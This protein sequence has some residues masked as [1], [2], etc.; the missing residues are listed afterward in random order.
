MKVVFLAA[1]M[2]AEIQ[3]A[4]MQCFKKGHWKIAER[5]YKEID[6]I[7]HAHFTSQGY[8]TSYDPDTD[9]MSYMRPHKSH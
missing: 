8:V 7:D 2:R 6:P 1:A 4:S 9:T 3:Y 5:V